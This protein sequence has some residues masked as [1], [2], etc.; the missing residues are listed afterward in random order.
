MNFKQLEFSKNRRAGLSNALEI[1]GIW[2]VKILSKLLF[3]FILR[4]N[5]HYFS[6]VLQMGIRLCLLKWSLRQNFGK[7]NISPFVRK[8]KTLSSLVTLKYTFLDKYFQFWRHPNISSQ[9]GAICLDILKNNW[10]PALNLK[11]A[12]IS[13]QALLSTPEPNDPQDAVVAKQVSVSHSP[14]H[15]LLAFLYFLLV[16]L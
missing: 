12:L 11:T 4:L 10:S 15:F 1:Y 3:M 16:V 13:L 5:V 2:G 6:D 14:S 8:K 9:T 7:N